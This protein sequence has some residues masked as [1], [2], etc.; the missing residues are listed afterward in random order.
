[1]AGCRRPLYR[2]E[3]LTGEFIKSLWWGSLGHTLASRP[4]GDAAPPRSP[5]RRKCSW[6]STLHSFIRTI[7]PCLAD[8]WQR[9]GRPAGQGRGWATAIPGQVASRSKPEWWGNAVYLLTL[10]TLRQG[11][12]ARKAGATGSGIQFH[13]CPFRSRHLTLFAH[14]SSGG[15]DSIHL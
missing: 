13:P 1:M 11:L 7:K 4:G 12:R 14:L 10:H 2:R 5:T 8:C 6:T 15:N 9:E 3:W